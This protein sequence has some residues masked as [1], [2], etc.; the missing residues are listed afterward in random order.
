MSSVR[1]VLAMLVMA[2]GVVIILVDA[3][4]L[5]AGN[6]W[7]SGGILA[8]VALCFFLYWR[9][10]GRYIDTKSLRTPIGVWVIGMVFVRF[11]DWQTGFKIQWFDLADSILTSFIA[12]VVGSVKLKEALQSEIEE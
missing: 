3:W 2:L 5:T 8:G 6:F 4:D 1:A 11:L 12:W 10:Y 9:L 7:L